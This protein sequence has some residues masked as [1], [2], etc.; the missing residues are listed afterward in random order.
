M[1]KLEIIDIKRNK[2]SVLWMSTNTNQFV[3]KK[4]KVMRIL[5]D[6][7]INGSKTPYGG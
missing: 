1:I 4:A 7:G 5:T 3:S 6:K 2:R